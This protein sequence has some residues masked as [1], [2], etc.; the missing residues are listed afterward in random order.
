M[1]VVRRIIEPKIL[2]ERIGLSALATLIAI[3]VGFKTL[4]IL[5]VF[6][7]PLLLILY[8]ALVKAK[9]IRYRLK[10]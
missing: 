7:G 4:G 10:I 1:T 2:G 8:K 5:G 6:L 9:V 3:W